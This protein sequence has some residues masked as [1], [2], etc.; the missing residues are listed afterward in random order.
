MNLKVFEQYNIKAKDVVNKTYK[1]HTFEINEE[2]L[3]YVED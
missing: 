3:N 2:D 1:F